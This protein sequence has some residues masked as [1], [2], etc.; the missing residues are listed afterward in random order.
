MKKQ[1]KEILGVF[2]LLTIITLLIVGVCIVG[3]TLGIEE[4]QGVGV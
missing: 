3:K 4:F 1:F 2:A